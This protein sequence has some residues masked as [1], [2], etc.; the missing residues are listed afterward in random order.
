MISLKKSLKKRSLSAAKLF[1]TSILPLVLWMLFIFLLSN[2][3]KIAFTKNYTVS[4]VIFK[5]L[6]LIEYAILYCLWLRFFHLIGT[7][8]KYFAAFLCTF[9]YGLSDELHQSFI[10]GR[11]GKFRDALVDA[12]GGILAWV[13][14]IKNKNL[15]KLVF[16]K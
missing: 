5:T 16:F 1:F 4:F 7:K 2:R 11:E 10:F 14:T 6:H 15:R 8:Q 13:L 3:Q 9:F 12:L